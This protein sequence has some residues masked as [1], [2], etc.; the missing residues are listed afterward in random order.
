MSDEAVRPSPGGRVV[1]PADPPARVPERRS[2]ARA[3]EGGAG[4]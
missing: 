1:R 4:A 2:G 3:A